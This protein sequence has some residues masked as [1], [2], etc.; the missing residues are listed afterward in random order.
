MKRIKNHGALILVMLT[1]S[2]VSCKKEYANLNSPTV[3]DYLKDASKDQLNGLVT[4]ALSGMRNNEAA[5]LDAVSV[6]GREI[7]R[8]SS[9]DP[10]FVTELLGSES[11][12]LNN[13]GFY[14]T[15]PWASRYRV[16]KN[17]NVLIEAATNSTQVSEAEKKGYTGFAKTI[18]AYELLLNLNLT[19]NNGVR[20]EVSDPNNLG[21]ILDYDQSILAIATLLDEAKADLTGSSVV[22]TLTPGF[23]GFS[24]VAGFVKFNRALAARVAVY[25]KEWAAALVA[26][27]ESFFAINGDFNL[28]VSHQF[29]TGSG[30]QL[31]PAFFPQDQNGEIRL[32]HP[33]YATDILPGD[34]RI[35]KA[36]LRT[37]AASN[38]GLSSNRD[39]WVYTSSTS[40]I[41]IIRN[42]E[43]ILIYAEAK[44]KLGA[45][46]DAIIAL[47]RIRTAHNIAVYAGAVNEAALINEML[48]Q[49]RYS[50]FFEGH[51]WIDMRRYNKLN[52]LPIDRPGDDVWSA[53]PIPSTE[54]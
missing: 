34:D 4:G 35:S 22:F 52:E 47:N 8:F 45:F 16:I 11:T 44:I 3:E 32:A 41:P 54:N 18:K 24:D 1:I 31:N 21:P 9:A 7:Y 12:T 6:I 51:R 33:N 46:P 17:T 37:A 53:M 50:L 19:Y 13:T 5:Y 27:N 30:D 28:G 48:Y 38:T 15:N 10:R 26:L 43:L 20:V 42:E 14:L 39:V 40:P 36:T 2:F 29:S 49:R 23:T 25:R